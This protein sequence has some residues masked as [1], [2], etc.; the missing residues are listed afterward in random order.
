[1]ETELWTTAKYILPGVFGVD[2]YCRRRKFQFA[3]RKIT[4]LA[5]RKEEKYDGEKKKKWNHEKVSRK[6]LEG[7]ITCKS[8]FSLRSTD[9]ENYSIENAERGFENFSGTGNASEAKKISKIKSISYD[10]F[11]LEFCHFCGGSRTEN[12]EAI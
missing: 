5:E 8:F 9:R 4:Y 3:K 1:M 2:Y 7:C 10:N 12:L 11:Y 6:C